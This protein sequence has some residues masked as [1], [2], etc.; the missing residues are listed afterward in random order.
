MLTSIEF[1]AHYKQ[2]TEGDCNT[3]APGMFDFVGKAKHKAWTE[4]KGS[5]TQEQAKEKYV[6]LLLDVS[7]RRGCNELG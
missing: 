5:M 1:Y 3:A 6:A 7:H 2:A 4:L